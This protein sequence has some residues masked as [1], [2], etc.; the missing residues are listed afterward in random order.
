MKQHIEELK[1]VMALHGLWQADMPA[2]EKLQSTQPFAIDTLAPEEWLQWVFVYRIETMLLRGQP[3]PS[4]FEI[5]PYFEQVWQ[6]MPQYQDV[7]H[8]LKKIDGASNV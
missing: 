7:I 2:M 5:T 4:K 8:V 6:S 1:Q 3:L